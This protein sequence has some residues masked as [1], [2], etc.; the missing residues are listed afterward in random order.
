M[1]AKWMAGLAVVL[2]VA[3]GVVTNLLTEKWS[4]T[5]AVGFAVLLGG[6]VTVTVL[7]ASGQGTDGTSRLE[8]ASGGRV[9]GNRLTG[10]RRSRFWLR[11]TRRGTVGRNTV[12]LEHGEAVLKARGGQVEDNTIE[13][14]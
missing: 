10:G 3:V 7:A 2:S 1:S 8:A 13:G 14:R 12:N 9:T 6:L 5:L 4:W 11:A